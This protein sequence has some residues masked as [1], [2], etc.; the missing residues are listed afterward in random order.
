MQYLH[1][2][3]ATLSLA[4]SIVATE[5]D[6]LPDFTGVVP[7]GQIR[8]LDDTLVDT[9]EVSWLDVATRSLK[10]YKKNTAGWSE[11]LAEIDIKFVNIAEEVLFTTTQQIV[12]VKGV[13]RA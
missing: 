8:M 11:G 3:G 4:G 5:G 7:S 10:V 1:K 6:T 12:V 2:K 9:L 13:T